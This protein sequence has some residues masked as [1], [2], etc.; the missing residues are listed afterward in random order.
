MSN[1][2]STE[3][4][5]ILDTAIKSDGKVALPNVDE[6]EDAQEALAAISMCTKQAETPYHFRL[7]EFDPPHGVQTH[8]VTWYPK[9][10]LHTGGMSGQF[11][12]S[13][14]ILASRGKAYS[15]FM[16]E[17][18]WDESGANHS[19][20]WHPMRCKKCGF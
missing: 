11:D 5:N 8:E 7:R 6:I 13:G 17:H 12:G 19:R 14:V 15:F 10:F 2:R 18:E 3:F 16:C 20:G 4:R 9:I 1:V